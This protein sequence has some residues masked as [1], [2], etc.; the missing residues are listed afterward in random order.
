MYNFPKDE[1]NA[2]KNNKA[3]IAC[4]HF[5]RNGNGWLN[6]ACAYECEEMGT[7]M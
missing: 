4:Y 3:I 7:V 2:N 6:L 5:G 1:R